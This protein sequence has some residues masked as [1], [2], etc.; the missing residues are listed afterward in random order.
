M[1]L[2]VC[3][4]REVEE[5]QSYYYYSN[6]GVSCYIPMHGWEITTNVKLHLW[7]IKIVKLS[8]RLHQL[9][10]LLLL[11]DAKDICTVRSNV[12]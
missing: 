10:H 8:F 9:M 11:I 2:R 5:T 12:N 3:L 1:L 6:S 7:W 4:M